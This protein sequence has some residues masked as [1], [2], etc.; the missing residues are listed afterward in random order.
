MGKKA[1][2]TNDELVKRWKRGEL[3]DQELFEHDKALEAVMDEDEYLAEVE[4]AIALSIAPGT[5]ED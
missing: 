5:E 4:D 2:L 3:S 1:L